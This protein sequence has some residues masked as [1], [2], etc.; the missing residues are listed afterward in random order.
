M[1]KKYG[2]ILVCLFI[3]LCCIACNSTASEKISYTWVPLDFSNSTQDE[4]GNGWQWNAKEKTLLLDGLQLNW[5]YDKMPANA[6]IQL[7][8]D[9]KIHLTENSTNEVR[10]KADELANTI[11][12]LCEENGDLSIEGNGTLSMSGEIVYSI[13]AK[14]GNII[15][16][17]GTI[18]LNHKKGYGIRAENGVYIQN[19]GNITVK[20]TM[21]VGDNGVTINGGILYVECQEAPLYAQNGNVVINDGVVTS[22][23]S[24]EDPLA[25]ILGKG[26][27]VWEADADS[28]WIINGGEFYTTGIKINSSFVVNDGYVQIDGVGINLDYMGRYEQNGGQVIVHSEYAGITNTLSSFS[29]NVIPDR[30]CLNGGQLEVHCSNPNYS[31][32][33]FWVEQPEKPNVLGTSILIG[34]SMALQ[35]GVWA[36]ENSKHYPLLQERDQQEESIENI[37]Q[38]ITTIQPETPNETQMGLQDIVITEKTI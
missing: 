3:G 9:S 29:E 5:D 1:R 34:E 22:K 24:G 8:A 16:E 14:E 6:A 13:L 19:N 36:T 25:I 4:S 7:P 33:E 30:I 12:V 20:D 32:I 23:Q 27:A 10:I 37:V 26:I 15:I 17:N 35:Q 28:N 11:V 31:A 38:F 18:Q 2:Y 21:V